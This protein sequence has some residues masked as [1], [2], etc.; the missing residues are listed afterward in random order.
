MAVAM[1]GL[2]ILYLVFA[3]AA[4]LTNSRMDL[5]AQVLVWAFLTIGIAV[6]LGLSGSAFFNQ[7]IPFRDWIIRELSAQAERSPSAFP[8]A[9]F[10]PPPLPPPRKE[11]S[12]EK[13]LIVTE[14]LEAYRNVGWRL[15]VFDN[16]GQPP[17]RQTLRVN[18]GALILIKADGVPVSMSLDVDQLPIPSH[19]KASLGHTSPLASNEANEV[20]S[21]LSSYEQFRLALGKLASN[22]GDFNLALIN[23]TSFARETMNRG[24]SALCMMGQTPPR[25]YP[26]GGFAE[27]VPPAC[28]PPGWFPK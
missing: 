16:W 3:Q 6:A 11:F 17:G 10:K 23:A 28:A 14:L 8:D 4:K 21:F 1:I 25:I 9:N 18:Q 22:Q 27:P 20:A 2:M 15:A 13:G 19:Y 12:V 24:H 5:P 26:D 7:P